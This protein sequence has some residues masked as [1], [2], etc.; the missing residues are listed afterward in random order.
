MTKAT[1]DVAQTYTDSDGRYSISNC[2][3]GDWTVAAEARDHALGYAEAAVS[4][5]K[6]LENLEIKMP[7]G[8]WITGRLKTPDGAPAA[9]ISV[10][11]VKSSRGNGGEHHQRDPNCNTRTN[12]SGEF[13]LGPVVEGVEFELTCNTDDDKMVGGFKAEAGK[14]PVEIEVSARTKVQ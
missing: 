8:S 9:N 6:P 1:D 13:R 3:A 2:P 12:E 11:I 5:S 14:E 7:K 10:S 4:P